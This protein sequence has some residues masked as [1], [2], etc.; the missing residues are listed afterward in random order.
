MDN[1]ITVG[2]IYNDTRLKAQKYTEQ[3]WNVLKSNNKFLPLD[4]ALI[5]DSAFTVVGITVKL[6]YKICSLIIYVPLIHQ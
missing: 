5:T 4:M 6:C 1:D 3:M 2:G